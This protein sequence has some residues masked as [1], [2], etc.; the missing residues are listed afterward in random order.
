M[1][2]DDVPLACIG[3]PSPLRLLPS[4]DST[5]CSLG[6]NPP[7]SS[8]PLGALR[9][10]LSSRS[11]SSNDVNVSSSSTR[12]RPSIVVIRSIGSRASTLMNQI[13][14]SHRKAKTSFSH[15]AGKRRTETRFGP[16]DTRS[17]K[18]RARRTEEPRS[19]FVRS[20]GP[21]STVVEHSRRKRTTKR[22]C[23]RVDMWNVI[24]LFT[25]T[26]IEKARGFFFIDRINLDR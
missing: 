24:S 3:D 9:G 26:F 7:P 4:N 11:S 19:A 22:G 20:V 14:Q 1:G 18:A 13:N 8:R 16:D 21:S 12:R 10:R 5:D 15:R 23:E 17:T 6:P 2:V 25:H